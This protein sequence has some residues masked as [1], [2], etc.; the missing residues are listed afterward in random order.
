MYT[1]TKKL[2]KKKQVIFFICKLF[3]ITFYLTSCGNKGS[4]NSS[5]SNTS[6]T[7]NT[8]EGSNVIINFTDSLTKWRLDM[9]TYG[10]IHCNNQQNTDINSEFSI[11]TTYYDSARVYYNIYKYTNDLRWLKCSERASEIYSNYAK[12][13]NGKLPGYWNFT[14]GLKDLY[15]FTRSKKY[16][17]TLNLIVSESS[18]TSNLTK[19][20]ELQSTELSRET[21]YGLEAF[22]NQEDIAN[23]SNPKVQ[24]YAD[25]ALGHLDQ[26]FFKHSASNIKPFMVAL[27]SEAL[28]KYNNKYPD[29]RVI[30]NVQAAADYIYKNLYDP[31]SHSFYYSDSSSEITQDLN[32]LIAPMYKWIADQTGEQKYFIIASTLFISGVSNTFLNDAK[33]FNQNYRWSFELVQ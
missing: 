2:T 31:K 12:T 27:T 11:S 16:L 28:I 30:N 33:H 6:D 14:E 1:L 21:A 18:Y 29:P 19:V 9:V 5:N 26:W 23:T 25:I 7:P 24:E 20:N 3:I 17:D 15:N 13:N 10:Q 32:L 8:D 22:L 4:S